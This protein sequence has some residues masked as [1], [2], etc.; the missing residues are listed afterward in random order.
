MPFVGR[1]YFFLW[2]PRDLPG[3]YGGGGTTATSQPPPTGCHSAGFLVSVV[4]FPEVSGLVG[5]KFLS[6]AAWYFYLFWVPKY[7]YDARGFDIKKVRYF[8]WIPYTVAGVGCLLGGWLS[9]WLIRRGHSLN[10]RANSR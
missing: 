8:A 5:A 7:L 9:G 3:R 4:L 6:D 2:V 1:G 10:F